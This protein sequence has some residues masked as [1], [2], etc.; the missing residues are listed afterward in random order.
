V[1]AHLTEWRNAGANYLAEPFR[2]PR[3]T[4]GPADPVPLAAPFRLGQQAASKA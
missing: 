4:R 1:D 3:E 2:D